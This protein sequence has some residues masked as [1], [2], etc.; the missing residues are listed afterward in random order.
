MILARSMTF[1]AAFWLS[2]KPVAVILC[3]SA[4]NSSV[5][6][7]TS[8]IPPEF[9]QAAFKARHVER[10]E[11]ILL[12]RN[13]EASLANERQRSATEFLREVYRTMPGGLFMVGGDGTIEDANDAVCAMLEL[14]PEVLIGRP[15]IELFDPGAVPDF[16]A[17]LAL[18]RGRPVVRT[19]T[20]F[21]TA[22]GEPIPILFSATGLPL[23]AGRRTRSV[24]CIA[25]DIRERKLLEEG[26]RQA[27]KLESVG[28]LAAGVAHEI[29][30][31]IQFVGDSLHFVREAMTDMDTVLQAYSHLQATLAAGDPPEQAAA[32]AASAADAADLPYLLE[33]VPPALARAVDGLNRVAEIV[34]SLK[35]FSHPDR[36]EMCAVDLNQAILSTITIARS[37]YKYVA[38]LETELA[39]LPPVTCHGGEI[40]QVILNLLVN[41]AHTIGDVVAGT[42]HHGRITI[43]TRLADPDTV[44]IEISDTGAGIPVAVRARIFDPFF[45]TKE[46]GRGTGQGL[47]IAR[48]VIR[49]KHGGDLTFETELGKGTTFTIRLPIVPPPVPL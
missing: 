22:A 10:L 35:A 31:P 2:Q 39:D 5:S 40:N 8:K 42:D 33:N 13:R 30:T 38:D 9:G 14:P 47:A 24:V 12:T 41:A 18:P 29:N 23:T 19:E 43:R 37:E 17:I 44:V 36:P 21:R 34:R 1:L 32:R 48:T 15:A 4:D 46:V 45:T 49:D 25:L 26:L 3:S 7:G 28:R 27:Q 11:A 20:C 6:L 16:A